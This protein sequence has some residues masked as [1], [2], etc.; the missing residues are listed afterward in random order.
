MY[1]P[2]IHSYAYN[3]QVY[4]SFNPNDRAG[5]ED[6]INRFWLFNNDLKLNDEKTEFLII[7]TSQQLEKL[8]NIS[9]CVGDSDIHPVPIRILPM[10]FVL[11]LG[12]P[13]QLTSHQQ[14]T[15]TL[16]AFTEEAD[17]SL[18]KLTPYRFLRNCPYV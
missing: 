13:W 18:K 12:G 7:G 17:I 16:I 4:I 3:S 11:I 6:R 10:V 1:M 5:G 8:D 14:S 2:I 9:I 15:A